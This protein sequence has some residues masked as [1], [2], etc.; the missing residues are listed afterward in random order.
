M[1]G[2]TRIL[3]YCRSEDFAGAFQQNDFLVIQIDTDCLHERPFELV[4]NQPDGSQK[5]PH[6]LILAV[7]EKL[8]GIMRLAFGEEFPAEY[9]HRILYAVAV[10]SIECWLLPLFCQD[11]HA[12][13]TNNC[14][15]KLNR[16]LSRA[17][18]LTINGSAK[19]FQHYDRLSKDYSKQKKL[20]ACCEKNPSLKI[21]IEE[22]RKVDWPKDVES[23]SEA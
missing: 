2:W 20:M 3:D 23:F 15:E 21:F 22:L 13:A 7:R 8:Q 5:L 1:G 16:Q 4:K 19:S 14:L 17:N 6:E 11:Q 9:G 18:I 10:D 12:A